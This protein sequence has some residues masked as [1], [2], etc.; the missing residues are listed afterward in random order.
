LPNAI[1]ET[2][3]TFGWIGLAV[4]LGLQVW[5]F[6]A[7]RVWRN[8]WQTAMFLTMFV[9]QF[10]GSFLTNFAELSIWALAASPIVSQP[11]TA[12][13]LSPTLAQPS[14]A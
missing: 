1:A 10:G 9:F 3:A 11:L 6:W 2:I 12:L 13:R 8:D 5:L 7:A 14:L 4:R